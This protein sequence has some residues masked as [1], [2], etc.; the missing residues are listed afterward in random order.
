MIEDFA[1]LTSAL[2][3]HGSAWD[4]LLLYHEEPDCGWRSFFYYG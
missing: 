3:P 2:P 4:L 1:Q